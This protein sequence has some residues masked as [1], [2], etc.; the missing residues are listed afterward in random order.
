MA[1]HRLF[2]TL[3]LLPIIICGQ[4]TDSKPL[5]SKSSINK[6]AYFGISAGFS[7]P[8]GSFSASN[9]E[10]ENS[11][12]AKQGFNFNLFDVG[13]RMG[14]TLG[15]TSYYFNSKNDVNLNSLVANRKGI[16]DL[17][18][19]DGETHNFEIRGI[20]LGL[21]ISKPSDVFDIDLKFLVGNATVEIPQTTLNYKNLNDE[22]ERHNFMSTNNNSYG[23]GIAGGT[24]IHIN[25]YID[26][27]IHANYLIFKNDFER[28]VEITTPFK[29]VEY[30]EVSTMSYEVF[31]LNFGLAF[32]FIN[33]EKRKNE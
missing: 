23:V 7:F 13:F 10:F 3:L 19:V 11:S 22:I 28:M 17:I 29:K 24:R 4:A 25:Q 26:F 21:L 15:A 1:S 2:I 33:E 6:K 30:I 12:F 31:N 5:S 14:K 20:L 18:Y 9:T 32:R 27:M 16:T 8:M